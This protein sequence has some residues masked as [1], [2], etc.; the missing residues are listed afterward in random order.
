MLEGRLISRRS[1]LRGVGTGAVAVGLA[2]F[3]PFLGVGQRRTLT[4]LTW[5]HFVPAFDTW[6]DN[7][8]APAWGNKN[9]V[10]VKIDHIGVADVPAAI[11]AEIAAGQG[12]DIQE[13]IAPMP[14]HE[15]SVH[16]LGDLTQE[17]ESKFGEQLALCQSASF[18]P[19]T[20]KFFAFCHGFVIDPGDYRKSLWT[21]AG[22]PEGPRTWD[23][24]LT[25]GARVFED[26]GVPVGIGLS[27]EIDTG[28]ATRAAL[29]SFDT[30]VQDENSQV[31]LNVGTFGRRTVAA[32]K[33]YAEIF[34]NA[35][36]PEVFA[37]GAASNNQ[38]L[39]GGRVSY[40]LNS[41][42]AYRSAQ[43]SVPEIAKDVFFVPALKGPRGT[44]RAS[45]HVIYNT[46]VPKY[47]PSAKLELAKQFLLDVETDYDQRMWFSELYD[48]FAFAGVS[49]PSGNRGY[50][51][52]AGAQTVQDLFDVWFD[53]DPFALPG[54]DPTKLRPLKTALD[55]SV[56]VGYPGSSNPAIGEVFATHVIP[57]MFAR[58]AQGRQ[59]AEESVAQTH[60]EVETI[61]EKWRA[62]GLVGG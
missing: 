3:S 42:S 32:V 6:L 30:G 54:E 24:L 12:H 55:W 11:A 53:N 33:L 58:V 5:S 59:T 61:F 13:Y 20:G 37:W 1:F 46:I 31:I 18:N 16:D 60:A 47:V 52:V 29:W 35:M 34:Q 56:V 19:H 8:F 36:T 26:Q 15:P 62:Q 22:K 40:I 4:M 43:K 10:E 7:E 17:A 39:I 45:E 50:P 57:N 41:I 38:A 9:N 44:A 28:M 49:L 14:Q 27:Q 21:L 51:A 25:F 2:S 48:T 23:D